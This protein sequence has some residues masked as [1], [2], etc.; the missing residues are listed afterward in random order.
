MELTF[1]V[2]VVQYVSTSDIK[3][4]LITLKSGIKTK[5]QFT[6]LT[7]HISPMHGLHEQVQHM[8]NQ[9][10]WCSSETK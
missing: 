3:E 6:F 1:W 10:H 2:Y 5:I 7:L 4:K 8:I 9:I